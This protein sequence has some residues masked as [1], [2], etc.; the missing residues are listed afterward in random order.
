MGESPCGFES[1]R[2]HHEL[3]HSL[4]FAHGAFANE[5]GDEFAQLE[6]GC[7]NEDAHVLIVGAGHGGSACAIALRKEKVEGRVLVVGEEPDPPYERPPL[8]KDYLAGG[9]TFDRLL[10]R[11]EAFW[12]D[13]AIDFR[14]ATRVQT[15]DPD[16]HCVTTD[17]G[18]VIGYRH[19]VWAAGGAPRRLTCAGADLPG[20]HT[21]RAR[22]DADRIMAELPAVGRVVI[23]GGGYIGL[24]AAASL[25][26]LGKKVVL[27][28]ALDRVLARVAAEPLSRFFETEHRAR[29][30]DIHLGAMVERILGETRA[31]GVRLADGSVFDAQMVIVGIGI[32][33][34]TAPLS[35]AGA[36]GGNGVA[37]DAEC[38]TSLPDIYAIGDCALHANT[39]AGGEMLR[40]ESVQNANDQGA[41][42]AKAI[43][44]KPVAYGA[45]PW[46]WS[47]QYDLK[48][49]TMGLSVGYDRTVVRGDPAS[50]SFSVAYLKGDR[51]LALDGVNCAKD[52]VQSR[53]L[54]IDGAPID[55]ERLADPD[56]PLKDLAL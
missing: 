31:S 37:V 21:L 49:Q 24:E 17:G 25:T 14:L 15:I 50:R 20:V 16:R 42:A 5:R 26:Q 23:V 11:P 38:R 45:I 54:I 30:V 36:R 44:G 40:I 12:R 4:L 3:A 8:S 43:A 47:D 18:D 53:K 6:S 48:L 52:Y 2:P 46:F 32:D 51:L 10:L 39:F 33:P 9:K 1:H 56:A 22:A 27:L 28:E 34:E 29:G 19:L 35:A 41:V 7:M 13:R 55:A